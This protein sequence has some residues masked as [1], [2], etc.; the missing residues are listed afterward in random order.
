MTKLVSG[1]HMKATQKLEER[2]VT[3]QPFSTADSQQKVTVA[4][5]DDM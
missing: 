3:V 1:E 4:E 2:I 5:L